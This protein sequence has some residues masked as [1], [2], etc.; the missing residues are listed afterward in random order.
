MSQTVITFGMFNK[1]GTKSAMDIQS[2]FKNIPNL[3]TRGT[4]Y[5]VRHLDKFVQYDQSRR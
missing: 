3:Q 5:D 4:T 2:M 1:N